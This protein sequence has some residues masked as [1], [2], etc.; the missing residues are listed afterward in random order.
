MYH[1]LCQVLFV[2]LNQNLP[3]HNWQGDALLH[4]RQ[5]LSRVLWE[6]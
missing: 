3:Q 5:A 4:S 2:D 6:V 1:I